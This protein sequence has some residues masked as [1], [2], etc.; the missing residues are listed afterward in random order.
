MSKWYPL[1]KWV[2]PALAAEVWLEYGKIAQQFFKGKLDGHIL[3]IN[4]YFFLSQ[5]DVDI[6]Q[7]ESYYASKSHNDAFFKKM[8]ITIKQVTE[9]LKA[10]SQNISSVTEFLEQYKTLT[11]V[12][13]PLNIV[14]E[15]VEK[16]VQETDSKAFQLTKGLTQE[17]PWTLKQVDE[18]RLLKEK[19]GIIP[20]DESSIPKEFK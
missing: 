11:G 13:M 3:Y 19:I 7:R 5:H 14:A 16:Y 17:K 6:I 10:A 20:K 18:M 9:D 1:G 4:G 15:G 12:W 2:E 8:L